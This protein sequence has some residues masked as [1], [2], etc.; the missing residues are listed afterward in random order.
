MS[1]AVLIAGMGDRGVA[2][3]IVVVRYDGKRPAGRRRCR[4]E[5]NIKINLQDVGW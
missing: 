2:Y 5:D 4:R 1:R 3:R